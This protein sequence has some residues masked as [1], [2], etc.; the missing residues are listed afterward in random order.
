M[1]VYHLGRDL[2]REMVGLG[3]MV[4]PRKN[5]EGVTKRPTETLAEGRI[6]PRER[7][8]ISEEQ[9]FQIRRQLIKT[10]VE[11]NQTENYKGT[12]NQALK[13]RKEAGKYI[14][15]EETRNTWAT[16]AI[17]L[18]LKDSEMDVGFP[19]EL[20]DLVIKQGDISRN[21]VVETTEDYEVNI[22]SSSDMYIPEKLTVGED[23]FNVTTGQ[24]HAD[25][26]RKLMEVL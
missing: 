1:T 6:N 10:L 8:P 9:K 24:P 13:L 19:T 14:S 22:T 5:H 16:V 25:L 12:R 4:T 3:S 17:A 23:L 2:N 15:P 21:F 7:R 18:C 26:K 20:G 11:L